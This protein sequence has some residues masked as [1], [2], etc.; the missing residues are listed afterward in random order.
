ME[1]KNI[2]LLMIY[3]ITSY[4]YFLLPTLNSIFKNTNY[5]IIDNFNE[6]N[7]VFIFLQNTSKEQRLNLTTIVDGLDI[8][9]LKNNDY[10][11]TN[12]QILIKNNPNK[13]FIFYTR[14]DQSTLLSYYYKKYFLDNPN[15]KLLIKDYLTNTFNNEQFLID[16]RHLLCPEF[17]EY[18]GFKNNI[19]INCTFP[20]SY[21]TLETTN[22]L[23]NSEESLSEYNDKIMVFSFVPN[24]YSFWT[25]VNN[26]KKLKIIDKYINNIKKYDIFFCK[27]QRNTVDGIARK[28][29]LNVKLHLLQKKKYNINIFEKLDSNEYTNFLSSSKIVISPFGMGERVDDDLIAPLYDTIVIKPDCSYV[30]SYENLFNNKN[31]NKYHKIQFTQHIVF[32]KPDFSDLEEIIDK[33]LNNY[34]YY[35]NITKKYKQE[36]IDYIQTNK[37]EN[38]FIE[39]LNNVLH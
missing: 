28:Y 11:Y 8:N 7:I 20:G 21:K 4:N 10:F 29:L 15:F 9:K 31:F 1:S 34:E 18:F 23:K 22:N 2:Y 38:D 37:Y 25:F 3:D 39:V 27:H 13:Q 33:I 26:E 36:C 5:N 6:S 12:I 17:E 19:P 24:Q 14:T 32:C 30:Y 35:L 16:C